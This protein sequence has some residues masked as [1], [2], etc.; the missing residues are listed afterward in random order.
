MDNSEATPAQ[1][2]RFIE[3]WW[4]DAF[5]A[6]LAQRIASAP[7]LHLRRFAESMPLV[8]SVIGPVESAK[9]RPILTKRN[10]QETDNA[11]VQTALRLLLYSHE[12]VADYSGL[13]LLHRLAAPE[14]IGDRETLAQSLQTLAH[15]R[16]MLEDGSLKVA[17][18]EDMGAHPSSRAVSEFAANLSPQL[19]DE[20]RAEVIDQFGVNGPLIERGSGPVAVPPEVMEPWLAL[21]VAFTALVGAS[22]L[23]ASSKGHLLA[24]SSLE[25]RLIEAFVGHAARAERHLRLATLAA[26]DIPLFDLGTQDLVALRRN[27][28]QFAVWRQALGQALATARGIAEDNEQAVRR[29]TSV[30]GEELQSSYAE[31]VKC[32]SQ[33]PLLSTV[34]KERRGF[35]IAGVTA[36]ASATVTGRPLDGIA[37]GLA[38]VAASMG[39]EYAHRLRTRRSDRAIVDVVTEFRAP[40]T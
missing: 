24:R 27:E 23:A 17:A 1:A 26:F 3:N 14:V 13:H 21:Q 25:R 8:I 32:N 38:A 4:G 34:L 6:H 29:A 11:I 9:L 7:L 36:V 20:V 19:M 35:A 10:R 22:R 37:T 30:V 16:P 15:V 28:E 18:I 31:L 33:S 40:T 2:F 39:W 12:V 5:D